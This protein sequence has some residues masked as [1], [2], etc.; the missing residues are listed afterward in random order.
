MP[1]ISTVEAA[2]RVFRKKSTKPLSHAVINLSTHSSVVAW[3]K[4]ESTAS[5]ELQKISAKYPTLEF[6]VYAV[7]CKSAEEIALNTKL[8]KATISFK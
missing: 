1:Y 3:C 6:D 7:L 2:G 5:I 8:L 4:D